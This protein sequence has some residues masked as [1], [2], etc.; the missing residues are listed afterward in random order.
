MSWLILIVSAVFEAVWATALGMSAGLSRPI[1][2]VVFLVFLG[3]SMVGLALAMRSIPV[4]VAYS[5]WIG[6]GAV[7]TVAYAMLTGDEQFTPAKAAVLTIL[8]GCIVGLKFTKG[9]GTSDREVN[10]V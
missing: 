8:I 6:I 9:S 3:L 1:P 7:L 4:S 10:D 5:V 2:T